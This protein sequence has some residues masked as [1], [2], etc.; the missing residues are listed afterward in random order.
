MMPQRRRT[1]AQ[2]RANRI[3]TERHHNRQA[4]QARRAQRDRTPT[5]A[6]NEPPPF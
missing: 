6:N 1:R 3:N 4:R 2:D 5:V